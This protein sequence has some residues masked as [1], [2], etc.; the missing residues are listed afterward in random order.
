LWR[1]NLLLIHSTL[2]NQS[3][4]F[5]VCTLILEFHPTALILLKTDLLITWTGSLR[6]FYYPSTCGL[7][8]YHA[9]NEWEN[10]LAAHEL[11]AKSIWASDPTSA[12]QLQLLVSPE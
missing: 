10:L 4:I 5:K 3:L 8:N 2:E 9:L 12:A 1:A 7:C 6:L 11:S